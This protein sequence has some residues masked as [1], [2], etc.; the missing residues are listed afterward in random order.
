MEW[1]LMP[2]RRYAEF[3]GRSRRKEYWMFFLFQMLV[4]IAVLLLLS[5][6]GGAAVLS[7]DPTSIAAAG[8]AALIIMLLYGLFSLVLLIPGIAV[9]VRRLHDTNRTGWWL[10]A[11]IVPYIAMFLAAGM[12][13]GS[14]ENAG[15]AGVIMMIAGFAVFALAITLFVFLVLDGT[16]GPNKYGDDPKGPDHA[17]VFA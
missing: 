12:L 4:Y 7:G 3:S 16:K 6:F 8:G 5:I 9:T 14:P 10:L 15:L 17:Q 11:P 13:A 1:M 2:L